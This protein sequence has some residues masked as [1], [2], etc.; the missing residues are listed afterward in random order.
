MATTNYSLPTLE[1]TALFD[2]VTDYNALANASDSALAS[3][4]ELIPSETITDMQG[5]ISNLQTLTG[6]QGTQITTLQSQMST[7]NGNI[8]TLQSGLVAANNNIGTL[9]TGLQSTNTQLSDLT[10]ELSKYFTFE[11]QTYTGTQVISSG[12]LPASQISVMINT[13]RSILKIAGSVMFNSTVAATEI[14]GV[15]NSD[16]QTLYGYKTNIVMPK[17]YGI[18]GRLFDKVVLCKN[19]GANGGSYTDLSDYAIGTDNYLY[20]RGR[21]PATNAIRNDVIEIMQIP[22]FLDKG[23]T[24]N[25]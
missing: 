4:A 24:I 19:T 23:A 8:S 20:L 1:S 17:D 15:V 3:V 7:A 2:L 18:A 5:Q 10:S 22:M 16:K 25:A 6:S 21:T 11:T 12:I 13:N 9:Q 14:P